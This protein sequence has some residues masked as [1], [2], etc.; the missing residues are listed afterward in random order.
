MRGAHDMPTTGGQHG[1][2]VLPLVGDGVVA[3]HVR[4]EV[5]AAVAPRDVDV[6]SIHGA[7][8]GMVRHGHGGDQLPCVGGWVVTLRRC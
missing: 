7:S 5:V 2:H 3:L 1:S 6:V 8:M 4:R